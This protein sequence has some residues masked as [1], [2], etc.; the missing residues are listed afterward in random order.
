MGLFPWNG[1]ARLKRYNHWAACQADAALQLLD[2]GNKED[3]LDVL[4][5]INAAHLETAESKLCSYC[6]QEAM[7]KYP[8]TEKAEVAKRLTDPGTQRKSLAEF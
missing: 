6:V 8:M 1:A 2:A 3:A 5:P 4:A 7:A